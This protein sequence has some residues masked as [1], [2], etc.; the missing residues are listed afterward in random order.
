[1][2]EPKVVMMIGVPLSTT[3]STLFSPLTD[4]IPIVAAVPVKAKDTL[5]PGQ[6]SSLVA[7]LTLPTYRTPA[8]EVD[9]GG[10]DEVVE[11]VSVVAA[12]SGKHWLYQSF[13]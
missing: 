3:S 8:E 9:V 4:A 12:A 13:W 6:L 1:M 10:E 5:D 7:G 2:L 11:L